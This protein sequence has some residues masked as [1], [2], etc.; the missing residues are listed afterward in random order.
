MGETPKPPTF[1]IYL[2]YNM[3]A[4]ATAM[5]TSG[6]SQITNMDVIESMYNDYKALSSTFDRDRLETFRKKYLRNG[7][8]DI[9]NRIIINQVP[10]LLDSGEINCEKLREYLNMFESLQ[11]GDIIPFDYIKNAGPKETEP[12]KYGDKCYQRNIHHL[13]RFSHPG[14]WIVGISNLLN[15]YCDGNQVKQPP[16]KKRRLNP[17]TPPKGGKKTRK[18]KKKT[19]KPKKKT[20]KPKKRTRKSKT[21]SRKNI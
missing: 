12:C 11:T 15:S 10:A 21:K 13:K 18:S 4:A 20:R 5:D 7:S 6:E 1:Y 16:R 17:P 2:L 19:R 8:H 14:L 3:A 9:Y